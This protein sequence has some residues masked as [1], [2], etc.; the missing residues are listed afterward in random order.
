MP[1]I[2][3]RMTRDNFG[4]LLEP[5]HRKVFFDSYNEKP[6]QYTK[7]FKKGKMNKKTETY[8]HEGAFGMWETNTEGST[9]NRSKMSEGA[10]AT[11]TAQRYDKSYEVTWE[12]VQD[13][14][15]SV[16]KGIGQGG[17][18]KALGKGLRTTEEVKCADVI[19]NGF[20]T[21]GYDGVPLFSSTHPLTDSTDTCSNLITGALTDENLK[22]ALTL[23]RSQVDEAGL[24][25]QAHAN[26]LV[27]APELEF[28]A[29]AI[30]RSSL[31]SGTNYNDVNTVPELEVVVWDYLAG[32]TIWFI[33]DTSFE[34]LMFLTREAPIFRS[35]RIPDTMDWRMIGYARWDEGYVDWRGLVG[36]LRNNT[37]T[38]SY[39]N[40]I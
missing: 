14:Q 21:V 8:V 20:T 33:Q 40:I 22:K 11:F 24:L 5:T 9:F 7:V 23:M 12:L 39:T 26:Q 29:K 38:N 17:S 16:F 35:E 18:A 27:V 34:N 30:V 13:D 2:A 32:T 3:T 1:S 19:K 25:I 6:T 15:Y 28:T 10:K 37:N 31:Q 4:E 36:S